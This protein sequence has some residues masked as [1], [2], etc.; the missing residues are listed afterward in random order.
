MSKAIKITKG[1]D[2]HLFG[3]A[4]PEVVETTVGEYAVKPRDFV[5]ITPKLLVEQGDR[6]KAGTP[7]FFAKGKEQVKFTS[8][9][10][11]TVK[12]IERGEKRVVEAIRIVPDNANE[13][14]DF[15]VCSLS[16]MSAEQIKDKM[17]VSGVWTVLRQRPYDVVPSPDTNPKCIVVRGFS[18]APLAPD[19]AITLHGQRAAMQVGIDALRKL[20]GGKVHL[21]VHSRL[22]RTDELLKLENVQINTFEGKHP[23]GNVS[24]QIEK[25]DPLN[26]G[27]RI[28]YVDA[29]DLPVIG[30]L[31]L[32]GRYVTDRIVAL[33]GEQVT[34]PQYYKVK[35]GASIS[36]LIFNNI[37][38]ENVRYI[39]G[40]IL[41]GK[42]IDKDGFIS[43]YDNQVTV[44]KEGDHRDFMG[45]LAPSFDKLSFSRT[46]LAGFLK[47]STKRTY[48]VDTNL[49]GGVRPFVVTG[50]FEKVF[51]MDI[52]PLQLIKAC[53]VEDIDLMEQLGIYEVAPE[54]FALC[55]FVDPSKNDIQEIIR[56]G[57]ELMRKEM[58]E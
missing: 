42:R 5:G 37:K 12:A 9:V 29:N 20:T 31:F 18:S 36:S 22:S 48:S 3:Q 43:A 26:K 1:L 16:E 17:L 47:N 41:T 4:K 46:F 27:E 33:T 19:Y 23:C 57:L 24:V 15:S 30:K 50:E 51:P 35:K 14:E 49:H 40:D 39:S 53:V 58:G 54:D 38:S 6:V 28:W 10:S 45:W 56:K 7:L 55:E 8:P 32:E 13:Y 44:V 2:L 11:G 21:N 34:H 52:Y 25:T